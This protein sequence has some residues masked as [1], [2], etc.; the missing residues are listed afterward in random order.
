MLSSRYPT[1]HQP[2]GEVSPAFTPRACAVMLY[3]SA[4][5]QP[6]NKARSGHLFLANLPQ[7]K[8]HATTRKAGE[9]FYWG[10]SAPQTPWSIFLSVK[11]GQ[12]TSRH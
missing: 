9:L 11:S 12:T 10:D 6:K 5:T 1:A 7:S 4:Y 3:C 2:K 8:K